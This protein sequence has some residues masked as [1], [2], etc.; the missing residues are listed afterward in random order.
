MPY[1]ISPIHTTDD[2]QGELSFDD[3]VDLFSARV[4]GWQIGVA[5]EMATKQVSHRG[6]AQLLVVTSYFEMIA[7]YH[8]GFVGEGKSAH[9]FKKGM[10]ITFPEIPSDQEEFLTIFYKSVRNGLYHAGMTRPNVLLTDDLPSGSI[11][12]HTETGRIAISPDRFV[13][14][15]RIRFE[16]FLEQLRNP[17]NCGLRRNFET[18]FDSESAWTSD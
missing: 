8:D 17:A 6:F 13:E 11:G 5:N 16:S 9:Y 7:K 18:R 15:L 1:A 4:K 14:D 3:K 10:M 2:F 12:Y